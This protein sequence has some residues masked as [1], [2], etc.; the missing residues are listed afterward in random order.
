MYQFTSPI[1]ALAQGQMT[2]PV[3]NSITV[4]LQ[5]LAQAKPATQG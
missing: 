3:R 4:A 2:T 5:Q 1:S